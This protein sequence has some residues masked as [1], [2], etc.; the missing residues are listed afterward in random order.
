M[1]VSV[2]YMINFFFFLDE[3]TIKIKQY[4]FRMVNNACFYTFPP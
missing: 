3:Y 1:L 4:I 2:Y